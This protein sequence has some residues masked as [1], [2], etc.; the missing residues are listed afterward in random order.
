[1]PNQN[2]YLRG[3]G[4]H[5]PF[6]AAEEFASKYIDEKGEL[7]NTDSQEFKE[8]LQQFI[9]AHARVEEAYVTPETGQLFADLNNN[10]WV[11]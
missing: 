3:P 6:F 8:A 5:V 10:P 2:K 1:M 11:V 7:V 4:Y 9:G